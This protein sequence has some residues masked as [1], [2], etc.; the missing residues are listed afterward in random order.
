MRAI[1]FI[2]LLLLSPIWAQEP[3]ERIGFGSCLQHDK[4][5]PIWH[6]VYAQRPDLFI[7]LGDNIYGDTEDMGLLA[8]KYRLQSE[9]PDFALLRSTCPYIG[10]WDDH[11]YGSNDAGVEWAF[12]EPSK[13]LLLDFLNEPADSERRDRPGVYDS[14]IYGPV[15]KRVQVILLD[16]RWF[17]DELFRRPQA[18]AKKLNQETG[19]GPYLINPDPQSQVL[20]EAQWEWLEEQ[21]RQPAEVRLIGSSIPIIQ[22][23]TGWETWDNYPHERQRLY[24]LLSRTQANGVLLLSG[25]S[26]RAEFSRVD[27]KTAYPLWELNASGLTE[28]ALSRPPNTNRIGKMFIGDNFGLIRFN[29]NRLDPEITLEVRDRDNDLVMQNVIRLSELSDE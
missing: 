18:A 15:G 1:C 27:D 26:H 10:T 17:R 21:F 2:A 12:K 13:Q 20:G 7:F 19:K 5:Q 23:D 22:E 8:E 3:L 24:D 29:W 14:Y 16:T 28:N 9:H 4:P 25:D 11:D 6:A